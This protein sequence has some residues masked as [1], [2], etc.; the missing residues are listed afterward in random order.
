MGGATRTGPLWP[1]SLSYQKK[2]GC[3]WPSKKDECAWPSFGMTPTFLIFFFLLRK[4]IQCHSKRRISK[5]GWVRPSFFWYKTQAIRDL[6][7]NLLSFQKIIEINSMTYT[8]RV[9]AHK[10]SSNLIY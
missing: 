4:G 10:I 6:T 7:F 1:E 2:D 9:E 5:E 3:G 8:S